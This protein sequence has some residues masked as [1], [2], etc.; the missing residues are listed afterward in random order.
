MVYMPSVHIG[1][2]HM[3]KYDILGIPV[4][5][6]I[7]KQLDQAAQNFDAAAEKLPFGLGHLLPS[8]VAHPQAFE[9][10]LLFLAPP[11]PRSENAPDVILSCPAGQHHPAAPLRAETTLLTCTPR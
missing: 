8:A 5:G 9:W 11:R 6:T 7:E 3:S 2:E 10:G 1:E 4:N